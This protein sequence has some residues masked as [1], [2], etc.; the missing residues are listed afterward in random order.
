[1]GTDCHH[2][3]AVFDR[4][5]DDRVDVELVVDAVVVPETPYS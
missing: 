3:D 4:D 5:E 2:A 1:V